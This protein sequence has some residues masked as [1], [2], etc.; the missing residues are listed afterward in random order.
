VRI[1]Q[2]KWGYWGKEG[3]ADKP[4]NQLQELIYRI[5]GYS[6]PPSKSDVQA[7]ALSGLSYGRDALLGK[8]EVDSI[9]TSMKGQAGRLLA[10]DRDQETAS[11]DP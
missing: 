1:Q 10:K 6:S 7:N 8:T 11:P 3:K 2:G 9:T 4:E 5:S